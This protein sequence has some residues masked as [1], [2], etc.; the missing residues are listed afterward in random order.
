MSFLNVKTDKELNEKITPTTWLG[1]TAGSC[2]LTNFDEGMFNVQ[3]MKSPMKIAS[4]ET[5]TAI[6]L[7]KKRM[8]VMQKDGSTQDAV[9]TEIKFV[10]A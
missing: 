3:V 1:D 10:P 9:L 6:K 7:G 5:M 2:H 4:S 8:T